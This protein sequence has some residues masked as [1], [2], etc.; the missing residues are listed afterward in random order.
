M[1]CTY[2]TILTGKQILYMLYKQLN[3][4]FILK[5]VGS[6]LKVFVK[7]TIKPTA[8]LYRTNLLIGYDRLAN[9]VIVFYSKK[10]KFVGF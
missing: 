5:H 8:L 9:F 2:P 10:R 4:F 3:F 1:F 7:C 6:F